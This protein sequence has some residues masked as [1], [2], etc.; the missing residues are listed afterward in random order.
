MLAF[1][2]IGE[3]FFPEFKFKWFAD[4]KLNLNIKLNKWQN[5]ALTFLKN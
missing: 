5:A 4:G 3:Y 2:Y 1:V